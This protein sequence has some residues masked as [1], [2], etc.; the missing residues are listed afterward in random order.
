M[1]ISFNADTDE[2]LRFDP[3][4]N[5]Y[6]RGELVDSNKEVYDAM[7]S[8]LEDSGYI[9]RTEWDDAEVKSIEDLE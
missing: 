1:S 2:V 6:V 8:F 9:V 7:V 3:D 5:I 4:G